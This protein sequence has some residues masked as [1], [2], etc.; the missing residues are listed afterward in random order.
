MLDDE[1]VPREQTFESNYTQL[2]QVYNWR[3][4]INK[5]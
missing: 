5:L 4:N 2:N 1:S 3:I